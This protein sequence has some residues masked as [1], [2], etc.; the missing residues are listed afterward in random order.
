M[1]VIGFTACQ[2]SRI[3][4]A[5]IGIP[6]D[7]TT[8]ITTTVKARVVFKVGAYLEGIFAANPKSAT[9]AMYPSLSFDIKTF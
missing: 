3:V 4:E 2:L 7:R 8:T 1:L 6:I 5:T 9:T